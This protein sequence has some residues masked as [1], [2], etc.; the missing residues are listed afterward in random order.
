MLVSDEATG[1]RSLMPKQMI[2]LY[3]MPTAVMMI[4]SHPSGIFYG[5]QVGGVA[6]SQEELEGVL[7]PV[8]LEPAEAEQLM[9]L[10][11]PGAAALNAEVA[12][13]IDGILSSVP[14]SRHLKVDRS[15]LRDSCE[16]W[17]FVVG[18]TPDDNI[19]QRER[20]YFGGIY[21]FGAIRGVL[22]W[23]NSD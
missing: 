10:P 19:L 4:V 13:M 15:R 5:N 9:K 7:V 12:D 2:I 20:P 23:P 1:A 6:C 3:N 18:E 16:A 14:F 17:V 11:F 8:G 22:T 21:G